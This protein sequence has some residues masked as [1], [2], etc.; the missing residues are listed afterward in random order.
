MIIKISAAGLFHKD[1]GWHT[2]R[3]HFAFG[4]YED[5]TNQ[6]LGVLNA[7]NDFVVQPN[8]GFETHS[9]AE[10]EIISYC[11]DGTL[12]HQDSMGNNN[13]LKRGDSQYTCTGSGITH[14]EMNGSGN[15]ILRFLQIWILPNKEGL[16]PLYR[17]KRILSASSN[18]HLRHIASGE[19]KEGVMQ[20]AQDAN[21]FAAEI[22]RNHQVRFQNKEKRQSYVLCLEGEISANSIRL[23]ENDAIKLRG[24][25]TLDFAAR[26][27]SHLLIVEMAEG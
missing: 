27:D 25:E 15:D 5:P 9:H 4:D 24:K 3:F 11:V 22:S 26:E 12:L 6:K 18:G 16:Q 2:G 20:I 21:I 1:Y 8:N 7:L 17:E 14:S 10:M 23:R 13:E 19:K